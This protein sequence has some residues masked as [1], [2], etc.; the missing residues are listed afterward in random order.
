MVTT[1]TVKKTVKKA[2]PKRAAAKKTSVKKAAPMQSFRVY[3]NPKPF[4]TFRITR[5]TAY[6]VI[7]LAIVAISQLWLLKIQLDISNLTDLII[8]E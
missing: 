4:T 6:W 3:K 7:L 2:A 5:Q 8:A 1:K